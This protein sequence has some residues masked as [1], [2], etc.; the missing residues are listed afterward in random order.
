MV[1]DALSSLLCHTQYADMQV[2][3]KSMADKAGDMMDIVHDILLTA[4]L[5]DKERFKQASMRAH[6]TAAANCPNLDRVAPEYSLATKS[7]TWPSSC[8]G[9]KCCTLIHA[10]SGPFFFLFFSKQMVLETKSSLEAGIVGAGHSYAGSRLDAQRNVAG[11]VNEQMGGVSYLDYI[12]GL[13]QR[14]DSDWEGVQADLEAIRCVRH[15]A[16]CQ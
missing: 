8:N 2:R 3:G 11:W 9:M 4:R 6:P 14:V 1:T 12:R 16:G 15:V 13:V 7:Q 5:D 10:S